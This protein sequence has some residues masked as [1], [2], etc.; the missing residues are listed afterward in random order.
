VKRPK[1]LC[2]DLDG[3]LLDPSGDPHDADVR[4]IHAALAS[5]VHVSIVTGRLYS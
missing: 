4:A 2:I 5:G 3:T 1:L